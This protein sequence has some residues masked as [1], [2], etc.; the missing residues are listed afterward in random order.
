[1]SR[2]SCSPEKWGK[3]TPVLKAYRLRNCLFYFS[4]WRNGKA[5]N[6]TLTPDKSDD[7]SSITT[8]HLWQTMN[9][10]NAICPAL[11]TSALVVLI[12]EFSFLTKLNKDNLELKHGEWIT[13]TKRITDAL[14]KRHCYWKNRKSCHLLLVTLLAK[15]LSIGEIKTEWDATLLVNRKCTCL[16]NLYK[17]LGITTCSTH[18]TRDLSIKSKLTEKMSFHHLTKV[19]KLC[20]VYF[21]INKS[22]CV[23][24]TKKLRNKETGEPFTENGPEK[25]AAVTLKN[26]G[27][28]LE[29]MV[30]ASN[31]KEKP[32][33]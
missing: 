3:I 9:Q 23:V 1:M 31:G 7:F 18:S 20:L 26:A 24:E 2:S 17:A 8:D 10:N 27:K 19:P 28:C 30:I 32:F 4:N 22:T 25:R 29:A 5:K 15:L 16:K 13:A 33:I 12:T 21:S 14:M 11:I 6:K